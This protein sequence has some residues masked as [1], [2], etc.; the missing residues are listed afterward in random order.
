MADSTAVAYNLWVPPATSWVSRTTG[1]PSELL[2]WLT[3]TGQLGR[4]LT[5]GVQ[6]SVWSTEPGAADLGSADQ[7]EL[8]GV[9]V[10]SI[11]GRGPIEASSLLPR[12]VAVAV[13]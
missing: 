3:M 1:G 4:W 12:H 8:L 10:D 6:L 7:P 11:G 2:I 5:A 13:P 9:V